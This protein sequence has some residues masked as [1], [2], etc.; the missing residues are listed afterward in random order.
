MNAFLLILWLSLTA[1][2]FVSMQGSGLGLV[3]AGTISALAAFSIIIC[4]IEE[5]EI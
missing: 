2:L 3:F 4:K 1:L 5:G